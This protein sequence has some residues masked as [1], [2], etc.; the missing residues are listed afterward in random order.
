MHINLAKYEELRIKNASQ[1]ITSQV[2]KAIKRMAFDYMNLLSD[3]HGQEAT[4]LP[5][6]L[7]MTQITQQLLMNEI[8]ICYWH[9]LNMSRPNIWT[10]RPMIVIEKLL[11]NALFAKIN[12]SHQE[13]AEIFK[14]FIT[15]NYKEVMR[16]HWSEFH[17][18]KDC[19][20]QN[21]IAYVNP[22]FEVSI[23]FTANCN[24]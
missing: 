15:H 24:M 12:S 19:D 9:A 6:L 23:N 14:S 5:L 16:N 18:M 7:K 13:E 22:E 3:H 21:W 1:A 4:K 20:Q 10:Q 11:I 17:M 8:Q 2:D